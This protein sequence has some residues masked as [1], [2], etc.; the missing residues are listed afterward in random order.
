M[1]HECR[2]SRRGRGRPCRIGAGRHR[3]LIFRLAPAIGLLKSPWPV[4]RIW[5]ANRPET[6]QEETI[7]LGEGGVRLEIGR[8]DGAVVLRHLDAASFVFRDAI[9]RGATLAAAT[10]AV[11]T[12][13]GRFD[14]EAALAAL[15]AESA[16]V[17]S[18][19]APE[20]AH[21]SL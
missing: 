8:H 21:A 2:R 4:D 1:A 5:R 16:V 7:D 15:F 17:A 20:A 11:L 6:G 3:R 13:D 10:R 14:L 19:V 18:S 12:V 9:A